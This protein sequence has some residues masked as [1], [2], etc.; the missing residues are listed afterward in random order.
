M[1]ILVYAFKKFDKLNT[2]PSAEVGKII[3]DSL[4]GKNGINI[5]LEIFSVD[6]GFERNL[7]KVILEFEPY[8]ILGLGASKRNKITVESIALNVIHEPRG[9]E[10]GKIFTNKK[11]ISGAD[12]IKTKFN[13][14]MLV[15]H[16]KKLDIPCDLSF[17]AGTYICNNAYFRC[18]KLVSDK[19]LNSKTVFVHVPL[20]PKEVNTLGIDAPS[21]P[22]TLI[23]NAL[24][25]F[26]ETYK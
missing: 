20:S 4:K 12:A 17:F 3:Y 14:E 19:N 16:L 24:A 22:P 6:Y 26:L 25:D 2:N 9:D 23:G 15:N 8:F 1:K 13:C 10:K 11:I 7:E 21:F 18:L 5:R